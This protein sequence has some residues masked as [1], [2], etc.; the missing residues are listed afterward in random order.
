MDA[1][2]EIE[3]FSTVVPN[4]ARTNGHSH[5]TASELIDQNLSATQ[6]T[7]ATQYLFFGQG[8]WSN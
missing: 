8:Y 4:S 3:C 1:T 6:M 5:G 7:T 2:R